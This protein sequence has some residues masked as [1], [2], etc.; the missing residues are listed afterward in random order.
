MRNLGDPF[1]AAKPMS[2][3]ASSGSDPAG[4]S[5]HELGSFRIKECR[6]L[7]SYFACEANTDGLADGMNYLVS[8]L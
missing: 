3:D 1:G 7:Q 8:P 5:I 4:G 6:C 2:T